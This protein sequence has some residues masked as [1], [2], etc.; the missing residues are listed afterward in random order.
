M[1]RLKV[2]RFDKVNVGS[3]IDQELTGSVTQ[4]CIEGDGARPIK[5]CSSFRGT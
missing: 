4:G 2:R 5:F 1:V 3:M